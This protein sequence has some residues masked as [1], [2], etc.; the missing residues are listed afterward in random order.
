M[1]LVTW[2]NGSGEARLGCVTAGEQVLDLKRAAIGLGHSNT[3]WAESMLALIRGGEAALDK[4]RGVEEEGNGKGESAWYAP[5]D[6]VSL[7]A[8]LPVPESVRDAMAFEDHIINCIRTVGLGKLGFI[9]EKIEKRWGRKASLARFIN[10]AWYDRPVYYKSNRFSVVGPGADVAIPSYCDA[11]DY[12]LEL[13]V[14][15]GTRGANI[16]A[17]KAEEHIFGYT[18]FNDFS[19]RDA[20]LKEMKARLGPAKGKDFDSGNAM[21]P[22][23]VT[24]D[25][26]DGEITMEA[27]VNGELWSKGST[28]EMYWSFGEIIEAISKDE[29]LHPGEFI[30]SGTCSGKDGRGCG[31]E[32]GRFLKRGDRVELS[33]CGIGRLV[34]RVV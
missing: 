29:T 9:D 10:R 25:E 12:E 17:S 19:A 24:R 22:M 27:R 31:L 3:G 34:N 33:A 4:A 14:V 16:I 7:L 11:F 6:D 23:L 21:G 8:P 5:L 13:G 2:L 32:M 20:Q 18:L 26:F 28:S 15:I 1:K 30:G